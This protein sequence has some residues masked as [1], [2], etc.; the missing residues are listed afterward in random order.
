[1]IDEADRMLEKENTVGR[2][3]PE[4][5]NILDKIPQAKKMQTLIFRLADTVI[6]DN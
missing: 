5:E 1:M 4:V 2:F 3:L 6:S